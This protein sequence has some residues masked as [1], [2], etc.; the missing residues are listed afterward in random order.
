MKNS[1]LNKKELEDIAVTENDIKEPEK[2]QLLETVIRVECSFGENP[3]VT[4]YPSLYNAFAFLY[5]KIKQSSPEAGRKCREVLIPETMRMKSAR[6]SILLDE[7]KSRAGIIAQEYSKIAESGLY[8]NPTII[9]AAAHW[10]KFSSDEFYRQSEEK[11]DEEFSWSGIEKAVGITA[12]DKTG[13]RSFYVL[14][15]SD[16]LLIEENLAQYA[17]GILQQQHIQ[18]KA[19]EIREQLEKLH[20]TPY[21]CVLEPNK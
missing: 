14:V 12:Q 17:G 9:K 3:E 16:D 18:K 1:V 13:K 21:F 5:R 2:A 8:Q 20:Q 15:M 4:T 10:L 6:H 7:I 19:E 11:H